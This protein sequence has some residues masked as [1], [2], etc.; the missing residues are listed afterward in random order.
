MESGGS[1]GLGSGASGMSG[2][3]PGSSGS[4]ES[5]SNSGA[6]GGFGSISGVSSGGVSSERDGSTASGANGDEPLTEGGKDGDGSGD[7]EGQV[8]GGVGCA[9][10]A[11]QLCDDFEGTAAGASGSVWTIDT[12]GYTVETVTAQAHSGTHSVHVKS[13]GSSGLG[14][15]VETAT[16]PATD[17]W[18]RS[19]L[20]M[21][22]PPSGHEV[23]VA[24]DGSTSDSTGEQIRLLNDLG[25]GRIATNRRSDDHSMEASQSIPMGAWFCYEWHETPT[26]LHVFLQGQELT[27]ADEMWTEPTLVQMRIGFERFDTGMGGDI[28]IDDVAV[29]SKQIGCD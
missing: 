12:K 17:F 2:S 24:M 8:E 28:Y 16:F 25:D 14:Y 13:T 6:S 5:G 10:G 7:G 23:F 21:M 27:G 15:I 22:A 18:G 29:D 26:E 19:Y 3:A 1:S 20:L 11:Y 4:I 9:T